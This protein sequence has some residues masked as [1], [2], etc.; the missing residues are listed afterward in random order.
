MLAE[1]IRTTDVLARV[2]GDEFAV[3]L[4]HTR[5]ASAWL[6]ARSL[7]DAVREKVDDR[8][9]PHGAH[10]RSASASRRSAAA[11]SGEDSMA[12]ADMA[13]YEAKRHG[14]D[15]VMTFN[16]QPQ[17]M[18][19]QLAWADRLQQALADDHFVLYEQPIVELA[20]SAVE[21]HEL[22]LRLREPDGRVAP[23]RAFMPAAERFGLINEIDRWV[24]RAA[25]ALIA[26]R[27][28]RPARLHD[29]PV[30]ALDR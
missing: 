25:V 27:G 29:Q 9:R 2:G 30:R 26:S 24:I 15:R 11:S 5:L 4:P 13:M 7:C 16:Q 12:I 3:L 19:D 10:D 17:Y 21:R 22:L 6:V 8:R 20:T 14:H 1:R 28:A 18:R 23:P